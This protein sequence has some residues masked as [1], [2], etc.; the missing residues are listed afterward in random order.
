[1]L[2]ALECGAASPLWLL[3][4]AARHRRFGSFLPTRIQKIKTAKAAMPRRT[5]KDRRLA[6]LTFPIPHKALTP[7]ERNTMSLPLCLRWAGALALALVLP[8][9]LSAKP[10]K[11]AGGKAPKPKA[12][13]AVTFP[14][15]L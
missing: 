15:T 1:A 2:V 12:G 10:E 5:P 4:S 9:V 11:A 13:A 8:V 6:K 7:G 14:P 3:W